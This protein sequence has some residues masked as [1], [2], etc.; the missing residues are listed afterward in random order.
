MLTKLLVFKSYYT[1][2]ICSSYLKRQQL[3]DNRLSNQKLFNNKL[4]NTEMSSD[5]NDKRWLYMVFKWWKTYIIILIKRLR[6][7]YT[8]FICH[9]MNISID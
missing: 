1:E 9:K 8:S 6:I 7:I 2:L 4:C 3:I 5:K